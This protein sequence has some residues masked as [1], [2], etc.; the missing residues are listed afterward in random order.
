MQG[1]GRILLGLLLACGCGRMGG[2][3]STWQQGA[4]GVANASQPY[5]AQL[6]DL[7]NRSSKLD[8]DNLE[9]QKQ[10]ALSQ[11]QSSVFRD[12]VT[13]YRKEIENLAKDLKDT[14]VARGEAERRIESLQASAQH[15]GGAI[16]T[17]NNSI[18]QSLGVVKIPGIEV[19]Q[20]D[21]AIVMEL[22]ADELFRPGTN[23][24]TSPGSQILDQVADAIAKNYPKQRIGLEGHCDPGE[25]TLASGGHTLAASQAAAVFDHLTQ[26][27]RMPSQQ[28]FWGSYGANHPRAA[29]ST[30]EGRAK[31]RRIAVVIYPDTATL[32]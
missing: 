31:N 19:R 1:C 17:A 4:N 3:K 27:N 26:R 2:S 32:K 25:G 20:E 15:R 30:P 9:L 22:P 21:Q 7:R 5:E 23:Q 14:Q 13:Q 6:A 10:L 12:Q 8:L 24:I 16:I 11:Q 28:L 18:R 29:N